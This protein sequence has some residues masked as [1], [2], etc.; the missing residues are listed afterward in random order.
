MGQRRV[1]YQVLESE[2]RFPVTTSKRNNVKMVQLTTERR[3]FFPEP[4]HGA[5]TALQTWHTLPK[6]TAVLDTGVGVAGQSSWRSFFS[7]VSFK[8]HRDG[9]LASLAL[10]SQPVIPEVTENDQGGHKPGFMT[11]HQGTA[12]VIFCRTQCKLRDQIASQSESSSSRGN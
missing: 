5:H 2:D 8:L 9:S 3:K 12:E 10:Y 4:G 11:S 6:L 7:Y 1:I